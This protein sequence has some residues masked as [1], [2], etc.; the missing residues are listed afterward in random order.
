M[1]TNKSEE[2]KEFL[3]SARKKIAPGITNVPVWILQK[4]GKRI[5][6]KKAKRHWRQ[7]SLGKLFK[8]KQEEQ[9]KGPKRKTSERKKIK[10]T[11]RAKGSGKR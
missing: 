8:K 4:A 9:K 3:I 7:T 1:S 6:N 2:K 5:Y 11:R 10:R